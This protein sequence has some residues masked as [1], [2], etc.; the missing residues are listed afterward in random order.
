[1]RKY[2]NEK[3]DNWLRFIITPGKSVFTFNS[4]TQ[5]IHGQFDYVV[6]RDI[7]GNVHDVQQSLVELH[8]IMQA[9]SRVVITYSKPAQN[10]LSRRDLV[11]ILSLAGFEVVKQ[12]TLILIPIYIPFISNF[13]NRYI[14]PLPLIKHLCLVQYVI[15]RERPRYYS[16]KEYSVSVIIPA[17]N[18]AGNIEAAVT[19]LPNLGSKTE[20]I[21]VEGGSKDNTAA[22]IARVAEKYKDTKT[23]ISLTQTGK[24]KGDAVREGFAKATG[25]VLMILDADLTVRP[26]DLPKFYQCLRTREGELV[27]GTRLVYPMEQGAMRFLNILGNKFFSTAFSWLLNQPL[28]D[29]LCGTKV[30]FRAD[31]ETLV[32]NRNY[33]GEFDPFGD[34][35]LIFGAAKLNLKILEIPIRYQART[36]GTTN[37][38]RFKHG[39]LLLKMTLFAARKIKFID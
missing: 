35:D 11:N 7:I 6:M 10:W 23:I 20:I 12:G 27:M 17:R 28:K 14:A 19:R 3:L 1:M 36:Y 31:Y 22:E 15:A 16:D 24:G 37:I 4:T 2:Y 18:E 21:F 32:K 29:T 13:V 38:S 9:D 26:E 5:D 34:F 8:K 25:D 33:F 30:M 39:W